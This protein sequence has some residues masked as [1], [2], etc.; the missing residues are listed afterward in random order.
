MEHS[1]DELD[2]SENLEVDGNREFEAGRA[3]RKM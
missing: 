3:L 2:G 1:S